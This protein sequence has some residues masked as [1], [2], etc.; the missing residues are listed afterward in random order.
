MHVLT[1]YAHSNPRSFC[2]AVLEEFTAGLREAGHTGEVVDLYAIGFD[3]VLDE[4][5]LMYPGIKHVEHVLFH[6]VHGADDETRRGYLD[7][8]RALGRTF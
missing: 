4:Y 6:A 3:P 8:A 7:R 1:I 2:H 5:T